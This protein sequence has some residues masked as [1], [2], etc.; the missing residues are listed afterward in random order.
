MDAQAMSLAVL[1]G[2]FSAGAALGGAHFGTLWWSVV[3]MREGRTGLGVAVQALRF[4]ALAFALALIARQGA[5]PFLAAAAGAL[6]ARALLMRRC[7]GL[8]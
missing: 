8:A 1:I 4:A 7:R 2:A 3:L 6:A 5:G